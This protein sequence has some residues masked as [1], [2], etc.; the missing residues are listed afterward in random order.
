M[1]AYDLHA[2]VSYARAEQVR[3]G[4]HPAFLT[5]NIDLAPG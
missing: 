4:S 2:V 3:T 1:S 5:R